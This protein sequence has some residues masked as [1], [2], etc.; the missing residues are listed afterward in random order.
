MIQTVFFTSPEY[1]AG[2]LDTR[3]GNTYCHHVFRTFRP[4]RF[5]ETDKEMPVEDFLKICPLSKEQI[6]KIFSEG[7]QFNNIFEDMFNGQDTDTETWE[8]GHMFRNGWE[9]I[10]MK[11]KD[12]GWYNGLTYNDHIA[13]FNKTFKPVRA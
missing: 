3:K 7:K 1:G 10:E 9:S 11:A 8:W 4:K 2:Y 6:E 13:W 5:L 12:T